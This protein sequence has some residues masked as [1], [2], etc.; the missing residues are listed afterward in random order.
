[1]M[2]GGGMIF[3]WLAVLVGAYFFIKFI[4]EQNAKTREPEDSALA[5]LQRR[6]ANGE[7]DEEEFQK[8]KK[9]IVNSPN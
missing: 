3:I 9:D 1:M 8:R 5:I 6:Y 2:F 7:I 4:I